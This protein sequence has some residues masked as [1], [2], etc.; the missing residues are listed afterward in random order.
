MQMA[1]ESCNSVSELEKGERA[2]WKK[3]FRE[4]RTIHARATLD[5][6]QVAASQIGSVIEKSASISRRY[7]TDSNGHPGVLDIV[8]SHVEL[9]KPKMD[10]TN[11]VS[12]VMK[13]PN[14][15]LK[16][17]VSGIVEFFKIP[18]VYNHEFQEKF[19][20]DAKEFLKDPDLMRQNYKKTSVYKFMEY[21]KKEGLESPQFTYSE[22]QNKNDSTTVFRSTVDFEGM[23]VAKKKKLLMIL[24]ALKLPLPEGVIIR[25][26]RLRLGQLPWPVGVSS[27]GTAPVDVPADKS[28]LLGLFLQ[29][30]RGVFVPFIMHQARNRMFVNYD[31]TSDS[32]RATIQSVMRYNFKEFRK[33]EIIMKCTKSNTYSATVE[34]GTRVGDLTASLHV[35]LS[36]VLLA[37][38]IIKNKND[39]EQQISTILNGA[40]LEKIRCDNTVEDFD[41]KVQQVKLAI[42]SIWKY[43]RGVID[44]DSARKFIECELIKQKTKDRKAKNK[45]SKQIHEDDLDDIMMAAKER[46]LLLDDLEND[47]ELV[48]DE[49]ELLPRPKWKTR[50]FDTI[51][52]HLTDTTG[53][54]S[55]SKSFALFKSI[56][57]ATI[58]QESGVNTAKEV[59]F[60][61]HERWQNMTPEERQPYTDSDNVEKT[62]CI[63]AAIQRLILV[64]CKLEEADDAGDLKNQYM[65]S[66]GETLL[67]IAQESASAMAASMISNNNAGSLLKRKNEKNYMLCV[68]LG[69][70][71][72]AFT[73]VGIRF[74][75]ENRLGKKSKMRVSLQV[76]GELSDLG[77]L[78]LTTQV[79]MKPD[80]LKLNT[81]GVPLDKKSLHP[82][83]VGYI[84]PVQVN[85]TGDADSG[86]R[87]LHLTLACRVS[88]S[89]ETT[90]VDHVEKFLK[91]TTE[92]EAIDGGSEKSN[93]VEVYVCINGK[94]SFTVYT[95]NYDSLL[96]TLRSLIDDPHENQPYGA[97]ICK[98]TH[99]SL[100]TQD[101]DLLFMWN[102]SR[103]DD[104]KV[105][106]IDISPGRYLRPLLNLNNEICGKLKNAT[107][108]N[109]MFEHLTVRSPRELTELPT[110]LQSIWTLAEN[111]ERDS[112]EMHLQNKKPA[113]MM[114]LSPFCSVGVLASKEASLTRVKGNKAVLGMTQLNR[115]LDPV[116][117]C[118]PLVLTTAAYYERPQTHSYLSMSGGASGEVAMMSVMPIGPA[119][120]DSGNEED[121]ITVSR[122]AA[123]RG[124]LKLIHKHTVCISL[125][126]KDLQPFCSAHFA[127]PIDFK[128]K[129]LA[130]HCT[131]RLMKRDSPIGI[132]SQLTP[133]L[134]QILAYEAGHYII[135]FETQKDKLTTEEDVGDTEDDRVDTSFTFDDLVKISGYTSAPDSKLRI[136]MLEVHAIYSVKD[137]CATPLQTWQRSEGEL[138]P[139]TIASDT[140]ELPSPLFYVQQ[141]HT[142]GTGKEQTLRVMT[143]PGWQGPT[144]GQMPH[145]I[146]LIYKIGP[147]KTSELVSKTLTSTIILKPGQ[148]IA[149]PKTQTISERHR[150]HTLRNR[151][152]DPMYDPM[153]ALDRESGAPIEGRKIKNR[154]YVIGKVIKDAQNGI[155]DKSELLHAPG[156]D[157]ILWTV[158]KVVRTATTMSVDLVSESQP[159]KN[160]DKVCT[161]AGQKGAIKIADS[162][163]IPYM[164]IRE[165]DGTENKTKNIIPDVVLHPCAITS[166][167]TPAILLEQLLGSFCAREGYHAVSDACV[168]NFDM[169]PVE[170]QFVSDGRR[171]QI[172][173]SIEDLYTRETKV[174][175][176]IVRSG[177]TGEVLSENGFCAPVQVRRLRQSGMFTA[178]DNVKVS[179]DGNIDKYTLQP[180]RGRED[181]SLRLGTDEMDHICLLGSSHFLRDLRSIDERPVLMCESC[182]QIIG[183]YTNGQY[184]SLCNEKMTVHTVSNPI[185]TLTH[186]LAALNINMHQ[187]SKYA[188]Y[189]DITNT[190]EMVPSKGDQRKDQPN[191]TDNPNNMQLLASTFGFLGFKSHDDVEHLNALSGGDVMKY[192]FTGVLQHARP[193]AIVRKLLE[194]NL[195][196]P[197]MTPKIELAIGT[198]I[199]IRDA[200]SKKTTEESALSIEA[201][202][203]KLG[204][205]AS[206]MYA[207]IR[208]GATNRTLQ[209]IINQINLKTRSTLIA[210][211]GK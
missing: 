15:F 151:S 40:L 123:E 101:K 203:T 4:D 135:G 140:A 159:L 72:K 130:D 118:K 9:K 119:D 84:D 198:L 87:T 127:H 92:N 182:Q 7:N 108:M 180:K 89:I 129:E 155:L 194:E 161:R 117:I 141:Y 28:H 134:P 145:S 186:T 76:P 54:T 79:E 50:E 174:H 184:C 147:V 22:K 31:K 61:A 178:K 74:L 205:S 206:D 143:T 10:C 3:V 176:Q 45:Q 21:A 168:T 26:Q 47:D 197:T 39:A 142:V 36:T 19:P 77:K 59:S 88:P 137:C 71:S 11:E 52:P 209:Y 124:L 201:V 193:G 56:M 95:Q 111:A 109:G 164:C 158:S 66:P 75:Q 113:R 103:L 153:H 191:A 172:T 156:G 211:H 116:T 93:S 183:T 165:E 34:I 53:N 114:E 207:N 152:S 208:V 57:T 25:K 196:L 100:Y 187:S 85:A 80:I 91:Q 170:S 102:P 38:G 149:I 29:G 33:F 162:A 58:K 73:E 146:R 139:L 94:L 133:G 195:I 144:T 83:Y 97:S 126:H 132:G 62:R 122:G 112:Y 185:L 49:Q 14:D 24:I 8:V 18:D 107:C 35:E 175:T 46:E 136:T 81:A 6:Y 65:R 67:Q 69:L 96:S 131:S 64:Q 5:S 179:A 42:S 12:H 55:E 121:A 82:S 16:R 210:R 177:I 125:N 37:Y 99:A 171:P 23:D 70:P 115:Q 90:D 27:D 169:I 32:Y 160:G 86:G 173:L 60:I 20:I 128:M 188:I 190:S 78:T 63:I 181:G 167:V 2:F 43:E 48:N 51:L 157:A 154:D 68:I 44:K 163:E 30:K 192:V 1:V 98:R 41:E 17:D 120:T 106:H 148:T 138:P 202:Q 150:R 189:D 105:V 166:R 13:D 204:Y 110:P 104:V 199:K 200:V